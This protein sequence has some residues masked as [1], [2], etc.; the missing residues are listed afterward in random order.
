MS[1][2]LSEEEYEERL[3]KFDEALKKGKLKF[4]F[5]VT[6]NPGEIKGG[7]AYLERRR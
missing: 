7:T 3:K 5:H 1:E 4:I 6:I 2:E